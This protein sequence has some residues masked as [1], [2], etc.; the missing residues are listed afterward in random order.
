MIC[1]MQF[2]R[3]SR[4]PWTDHDILRIWWALHLRCRCQ[5]TTIEQHQGSDGQQGTRGCIR[6]IRFRNRCRSPTERRGDQMPKRKR[7]CV[8]SMPKG[9]SDRSSALTGSAKRHRTRISIRQS[10]PRVIVEKPTIVAEDYIA[11]STGLH[12]LCSSFAGRRER[13][14]SVSGCR[15]NPDSSDPSFALETFHRHPIPKTREGID[16]G[17]VDLKVPN[18]GTQ[19]RRRVVEGCRPPS[20]PFLRVARLYL[21]AEP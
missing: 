16:G 20:A 7:H 12:G 4:D 18:G 8:L 5:R 3:L 6:S 10:D 13:D 11:S 9:D 2:R 14:G 17:T 21:H 1:R 15:T 19:G